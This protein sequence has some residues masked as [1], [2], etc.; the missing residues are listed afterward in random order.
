MNSFYY[1]PGGVALGDAFINREAERRYLSN[2]IKASQHTVLIAPRRYGKT[3]LAMKVAN[4]MHIPYCAMDLLTMYSEDRV[5]DHIVSKISRLV[6]QLLPRMTKAKETLLQIFKNMK[7]EVVLT[8][9]GQKL[10]L[11]LSK[12]P[13]QDVTDVLLQLD[14][15]AKTFKKKAVVFIDEFQQLNQLKHSHAIE[16]AIRHAVERSQHIAYVFSGSNR[17]LLQHMFGDHSRPFYRLCQTLTLDRIHEETYVTHL[18]QLAHLKWHQ[19]TFPAL[20]RILIL[21]ERHPFY[22]NALC[23]LLWQESIMPLSE[24]IDDIWHAYVITQKPTIS[25][26]IVTLSPNQ[27]KV[28]IAL[29]ESPT[30]KIQSI[31]FTM[32]IKI[33]T[34][35]AE[36]ALNVLIQKDLVYQREDGCYTLLDPVM[37]YYLNVISQE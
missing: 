25:H 15:T 4:E 22:T 35:S 16:A 34:S 1:F 28:L 9:F 30:Q 37:K 12:D 36:Q 6:F 5:R 8:A 26:D 17:H 3:S 10:S 20:E 27:R 32:P 2:R 19:H 23:Q 31:E 11:T 21:T 7:P 24:K 13:L 18:Q 14:E 29:A 33:S